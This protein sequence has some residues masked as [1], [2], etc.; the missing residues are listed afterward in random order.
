MRQEKGLLRCFLSYYRRYQLLAGLIAVGAVAGALL[1]LV[2]PLGVRYILQREL[3]STS[4][5]Q[6]LLQCLGLALLYGANFLLLY[7]ISY[8]SGILSANMENDMREDLF[9]HI[10]QLPFQFFDNA[11]TGQLLATLTS[12]VA[13]TGELASRIP[14]DLLVTI[15]SL[16]GTM[17]ILLYMNP[18][19]GGLVIL[20]IFGKALH[21]IWINM[22]LRDTFLATRKQ[23]GQLSALGEEALNG[24]R[25]VKAFAAEDHTRQDFVKAARLYLDAR[26]A[27]FQIR[28]YFSASINLFTNSINL[29]I[30]LVGAWQIQQGA[31]QVSDLVAYFLYVGIF[32]KPIMKLVMF[33]ETYQ[34]SM[35]GFRRFY[36]IMQQPVEEGSRLPDLPA[37]RGA[38]EFRHVTFSYGKAE[39]VIRDFS[40]TI[41]PGEKV[42]FVGATGTGKTTLVNLLLRFYK[43]TRGQIFID[44]HDL[45]TVNPA[46]VRR[47]IGL[48]QQD[49]FLFSDS[50]EENISFGDFQSSQQEVEQA[51]QAARAWEFIQALPEKLATEI[52]ERG[53]KLSGGQRQRL[54][55]ARAFLKD[56]PIV[57]LDEA[58]SSLDNIT[59]AQVQQE[60]EKL[61]KGRTTL[62]VA[63][64]LSTVQ[65]ADTLVVLEQGR[66][67]EKGS[68]AELLAKKG[69]YYRLWEKEAGIVEERRNNE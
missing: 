42:A 57:V 7:G 19:L 45:A 58:T 54:A 34:R 25:M 66:I 55:L 67:V 12:D 43:P 37:A 16:I 69:V 9:T 35:A 63:H 3:A 20:L 46:S 49:V 48:V 31:M 60:L 53:V 2:F 26:R 40:L 47:Q 30:L 27:S 64:R 44:G 50:I 6:V 18:V 36:H 24:I 1:E 13:E 68:P 51:A 8:G 59:E 28:S 52:G 10:Q 62:M 56:A 38:I 5:P 32:I 17:G 29:C 15:F 14:N 33:V 41:R 23:Y 65:K 21:T 39:P 61:A 11:R 22:K 4:W